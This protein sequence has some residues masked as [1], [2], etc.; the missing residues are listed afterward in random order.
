MLRYQILN[1]LLH[2][3]V[4]FL[5][6]GIGSFLN[7]VIYRLPLGVSVNNPRRS[8]CPSCKKQIPMW[9]NIPVLSWLLLRGKCAACGSR[10]APR[11]I[12]VEVLTGLLFYAVFRNFGGDWGRTAEW[13]PTVLALCIFLSLLVAGTFID[14]DHFILPHEI[15]IGGTFAGLLLAYWAPGIVGEEEHGRGMVISF[16]SAMIGL[17]LIWTVILLGKLAFG[18]KR[19]V[20]DTPEAWSVTQPDEEKSPVVTLQGDTY[21]WED[22]FTRPTDRL[23]LHS[24]DVKVNDRA[25]QNVRVEIKTETLKVCLSNKNEESFDL[26]KV[27]LLSGTCTEVVIPREAMGY[28][29]MYFMMMIGA[30][31]GWKAVLFTILA[32]SVIGTVFALVPRI[33]GKAEWSAR[34]PF[35]PYLAAGA[36]LWVFYGTPIL[37]WYLNR[38]MWRPHG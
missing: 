2:F 35:G 25:Y 10:I 1:S 24:P 36:A 6:A 34:I 28:G 38:T 21:E 14:I 17:G 16:L 9:Q 27:T 19:H 37:D 12:L 23:I 30:F 3:L 15:T 32:A 13:G 33:F 29:D 18:R 4:F 31:L 11:Y 22:L 7:V 8:F 26:E 5:G 20:F